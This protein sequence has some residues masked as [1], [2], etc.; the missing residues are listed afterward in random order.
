MQGNL[1]DGTVFRRQRH[2]GISVE[3]AGAESEMRLNVWRDLP[4]PILGVSTR[5]KPAVAG[6]GSPKDGLLSSPR[7]APHPLRHKIVRESQPEIGNN[8]SATGPP[9]V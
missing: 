3:S 4:G 7:K 1:P 2:V 5:W 8:V 9:I 6:A